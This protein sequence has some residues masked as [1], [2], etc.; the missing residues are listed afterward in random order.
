MRYWLIVIILTLVQPLAAQTLTHRL[1]PP[2]QFNKQDTLLHKAEFLERLGHIDDALALYRRILLRNPDHQRAYARYESLL[3]N[4]SHPEKLLEIIDLRLMRHPRNPD[5]IIDKGRIL[6]RSGRKTEAYKVWRQALELPLTRA[7]YTYFANNT[8]YVGALDMAREILI[9]GR[10]RLKDPNAF[11]LEIGRVEMAA[12]RY[13]RALEEYMRYLQRRPRM[14]DYMTRLI[15]NAVETGDAAEPIIHSLE[16]YLGV[17]PQ[18]ASARLILAKLYLS[19][20]DYSHLLETIRQTP[21]GA[22]RPAKLLLLGRDLEND[23]AWDAAAQ[24]YTLL[25]RQTTDMKTSSQ[26]LLGLARAYEQRLSQAKPYNSLGGYFAGN[27][28]FRLGG[29]LPPADRPVLRRALALYDSLQ[30]LVPY[31]PAAA[32]ALYRVGWLQ[33]NVLDD[34]DAAIRNFQRVL[35]R[36]RNPRVVVPAGQALVE[37]YL[38]KGDTLAAQVSLQQWQSMLDLDE[39]DPRVIFSRIQIYLTALNLTAAHK[40]LLNLTGAAEI[41][42]PLYNDVLQVLGL[43]DGNGGPSNRDLQIYFN[44]EAFLKQ[45]HYHQA[46]RLL[47]TLNT[48]RSLIADEAQVRRMQLWLHLNQPDSALQT[49]EM[50]LRTFP[51][52]PWRGQV[53]I[54]LGEI[55]QFLKRDPGAAVVYYER[56]L[57]QD[58]T[59]LHAQAVRR[60]L[61]QLVNR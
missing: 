41:T 28:F 53:L 40:E 50:F 51:E 22:W 49:G 43:I 9:Q 1:P 12:Q 14:E 45:H 7:Q 47:A 36:T 34:F 32:R 16:Q 6:F 42:D 55:Q 17:H 33:L 30:E 61:R 19:L 25:S 5:L 60:R 46:L 21:P 18:D 52:S 54:W 31:S 15:L 20:K 48:P 56:L 57:V 11:A 2:P 39:D 3:E 38:A 13:D 58:P 35:K 8:L 4:S 44:A 26:A 59:N 29:Q 37:A 27:R 23:Q 10:K 24:L